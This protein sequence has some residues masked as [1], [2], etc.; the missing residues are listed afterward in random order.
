MSLYTADN[1]GSEVASTV[2]GAN[3][4]RRNSGFS[5][6][7]MEARRSLK[8]DFRLA[9]MTVS[10]LTFPSSKVLISS[11]VYLTFLSLAMH[12]SMELSVILSKTSLKME[13]GF[14]ILNLFAFFLAFSSSQVSRAY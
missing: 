12:G 1:P 3:S 10:K 4:S 8:E 13:S 11:R 7:Y 5:N 14:L 2:I 6:S 9:E